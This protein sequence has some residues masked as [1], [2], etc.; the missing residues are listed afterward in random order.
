[1]VFTQRTIDQRRCLVSTEDK[2]AQWLPGHG[3]GWVL[4]LL[5]RDWLIEEQRKVIERGR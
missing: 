2:S 1:M 5:L 4:A 3:Y